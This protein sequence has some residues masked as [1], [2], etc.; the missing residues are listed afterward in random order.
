M[1]AFLFCKSK[2]WL[3]ATHHRPVSHMKGLGKCPQCQGWEIQGNQRALQTLAM[4]ACG[5]MKRRLSLTQGCVQLWI[6]AEMP[7]MRVFLT[8]DKLVV[9]CFN[10]FLNLTLMWEGNAGA[11]VKLQKLDWF[12]ISNLN[13]LGITF[14]MLRIER[15]LNPCVEVAFNVS[16]SAS[17]CDAWDFFRIVM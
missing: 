2:A 11:A 6:W 3:H 15:T 9:W 1:H 13:W 16:G 17:N 4:S 5:F 12:Y 7:G 10:R 14:K 8:S